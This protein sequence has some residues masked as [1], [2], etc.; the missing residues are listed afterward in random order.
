MS[1]S[2]PF[3]SCWFIDATPILHSGEYVVQTLYLHINIWP[4]SSLP[5]QPGLLSF[6]IDVTRAPLPHLT[7]RR[8]QI[9]P[10]SSPVFFTSV[11]RGWV[12]R[13]CVTSL[14]FS[15]LSPVSFVLFHA[16]SA[17]F[18][19]RCVLQ[20]ASQTR[21]SLTSHPPG[22]APPPPPPPS[23]QCHFHLPQSLWWPVSSWRT[24][25]VDCRIKARTFTDVSKYISTRAHLFLHEW[26]KPTWWKGEGGEELHTIKGAAAGPQL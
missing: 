1:W 15:S 6:G 4:V 13:L 20:P 16:P 22:A 12:W 18:N 11:W 19:L 5:L 2:Q 17:L 26:M 25:C 23:L 14:T 21:L 3:S 9:P 8:L 10:P 7:C 24:R